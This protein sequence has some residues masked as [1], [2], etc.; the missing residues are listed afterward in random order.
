M[1]KVKAIFDIGKTNKKCFLFDQEFNE[2]Y[3]DYVR[4]DEIPDDDGYPCDDLTAI[5]NWI[6][7]TIDKLRHSSEYELEAINFSAYGASLVHLDKQGNPLTPLYNYTKPYP[8]AVLETFYQQYGD[9]LRMAQ[10]TSSPQLGMLN[11]GL[12]LYW[13]KQVKTD[14]F[15]RIRY[16][17]HLP[18]YFSYVVT[19]K[20]YSEYTS[21][22]CHTMLWNFTKNGYHPWVSAE[23]VDQVLA[24]MVNSDEYRHL[25][26]TNIRVGVGIHDSSAALLPYLR[27]NEEP[28]LLLS[29]GTWSIALN[30]FNEEPLSREHLQQDC[31][32][33]LRTDGKPVRAARLFLGHEYIQQ[34]KKLTGH[35]GLP[36]GVHKEVTFNE[37]LYHSLM[38]TYTRKFYLESIRRE[39]DN[40]SETRLD[41]F[42]SFEEAYHQLMIELV[43]LQSVAIR[44]ARGNTLVKKIYI[45]GGFADNK[46][47]IELLARKFKDI[48]LTATQ[49]PLGSA[50][51]AVLMISEPRLNQYHLSKHFKEA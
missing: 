22:G 15:H 2:V 21:V 50:L 14:I 18:Q 36:P 39:G 33:F 29:T 20:A 49:T 30:P 13:L 37:Q 17:L 46:I 32:N 23:G 25:A 31:L 35:F 28:F 26:D 3:Q 27:V 11:S 41:S 48:H 34:A 24:P 10:E 38:S 47:F 5:V 8:N 1:M 12:Q 40:P 42:S 19:G 44:L 43:E 51:G 7:S 9:P 45:D 6:E 4:F 16:S